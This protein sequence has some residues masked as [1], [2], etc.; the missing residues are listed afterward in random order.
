MK[1]LLF[2]ILI[3]PIT[4]VYGQIEPD[5]NQPIGPITNIDDLNRGHSIITQLMTDHADGNFE[6]FE[7]QVIN[8]AFVDPDNGTLVVGFDPIMH[9]LDIK[10]DTGNLLDGIP[11]DIVY[12]IHELLSD[13]TN[14]TQKYIDLYNH[15]C[16]NSLSILCEK[17]AYQ[18][19][20][21]QTQDI[22]PLPDDPTIFKDNF[23]NNLK[24]WTKSGDKDFRLKVSDESS[25]Y[26]P[27]WSSN[28]KVLESDD[29]TDICMISLKKPLDLTKYINVTMKFNYYVDQSARDDQYLHVD[30]YNGTNWNTVLKYNGTMNNNLWNDQYGIFQTSHYY[31]SDFNIRFVANTTSDNEVAIDNLEFRGIRDTDRDGVPNKIDKCPRIAGVVSLNGCPDK[32]PKIYQISPL[33]QYI[34][35]DKFFYPMIAIDDIDGITPVI[36]N[37]PSGSILQVSVS[38]LI[39]C[40]AIDSSRNNITKLLSFS[41]KE[42]NHVDLYGGMEHGLNYYDKKKKS[43]EGTKGTITIGAETKNGT[44]GVVVAGHSVLYNLYKQDYP[45]NHHIDHFLVDQIT[46]TQIG[47]GPAIDSKNFSVDA[48]FIPLKTKVDINPYQ[49]KIKNGTVF[50]VTQSSMAETPRL[51]EINM[52]GH[53]TNDQGMLLYKNVT[54]VWG[55][56]IYYNMGIITNLTAIS[57]DSGGP[58]IFHDNGINKLIGSIHGHTCMIRDI[59]NRSDINVLVSI[60]CNPLFPDLW[61]Y[62]VFTPWER[63]KEDLNIK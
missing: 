46:R 20:I 31:V 15:R 43:I 49:V 30:F 27:E 23:Q 24:K 38:L 62:D 61:T 6:R 16:T 2:L 13:N 17:L 34:Q 52:Y 56:D 33:Y 4:I 1:Y 32:P 44:K 47:F 57:G 3:L 51:S 53:L 63:I 28:N 18:L 7:D 22:P 9:V 5:P 14:S 19:N 41:F 21:D 42:V 8:L 37:P 39:S 59:P 50:N 54:K 60:H 29:C 48:A 40:N 26:P 35:N 10:R 36:C 25:R 12:S 11:T 45:L 55:N 58:I